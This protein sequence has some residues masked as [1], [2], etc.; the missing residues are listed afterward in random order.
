MRAENPEVSPLDLR[1]GQ[2]NPTRHQLV[3]IGQMQHYFALGPITA[4][5]TLGFPALY[6]A[7]R[8]VR[9]LGAWM[10]NSEPPKER[11]RAFVVMFAV[12]G[13]IVGGL[14]QAIWDETAACTA[15]GKSAVQC[16]A[17]NPR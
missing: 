7:A 3:P 15:T 14:S 11:A 12:F 6:I 13:F 17:F 2:Q 1:A 4:A 5:F 9:R 16:L 10:Q 8:Q